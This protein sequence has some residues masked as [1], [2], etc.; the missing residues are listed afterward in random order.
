M[1]AQVADIDGFIISYAIPGGSPVPAYHYP[2]ENITEVI[3]DGITFA[4]NVPLPN[5][6]G[7]EIEVLVST[8]VSRVINPPSSAFITL[9]CGAAASSTDTT[10]GTRHCDIMRLT[11]N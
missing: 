8:I 3:T 2:R 7:D 6:T 4:N 11:N 10:K 5:R 9:E 1:N